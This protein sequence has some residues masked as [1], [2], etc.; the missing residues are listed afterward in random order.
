MLRIALTG[1]IACGKSLAASILSEKGFDV[2]EADDIAKDL[3]QA[4]KAAYRDVKRAFGSKVIDGSGEIDRKVL[5][6]LVMGD[7]GLRLK[8]NEIVHPRVI[9]QWQSWL[10][11]R[12][13]GDGV[14][15]V[16]VPLLY[17][18]GQGDGW[19][20]VICV[21]ARRD[22]QVERLAGRGITPEAAAKW[23]AAQM[24]LAEKMKM[25]D[26]VISNNGS[27]EILKQQ[28]DSVMNKILEI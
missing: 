3:M 8:L 13:G 17:E 20:A 10:A 22:V 28:I 24:K 16:V 23:L 27:I 25:S 11:E 12:Q 1:G 15:V 26:F 6:E 7:T 18:A 9:E 2:I 5:G 4:G 14:A 19:D 21:S